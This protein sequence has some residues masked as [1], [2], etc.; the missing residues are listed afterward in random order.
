MGFKKLMLIMGIGFADI[1]MLNGVMSSDVNKIFGIFF[2]LTLLFL[3]LDLIS[4]LIK[5]RVFKRKL[6]SRKALIFILKVFLYFTVLLGLFTVARVFENDVVRYF[7][8]AVALF[9]ILVELK[10]IGENI[11]EAYNTNFPF[12]DALTIL[13][14]WLRILI[15]KAITIISPHEDKDNKDDR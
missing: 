2:V 11:E 5:A 12:L 1:F 3:V 15:N 13:T 7:I 8:Y 14:D 4:G 10:S 9:S 6:E